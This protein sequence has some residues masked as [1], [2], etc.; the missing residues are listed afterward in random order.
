LLR[1]ARA[2]VVIS[3][4]ERA[5]L[6]AAGLPAEKLRVIRPGV[7]VPESTLDA[8]AFRAE[9]EIPPEAPLL[10]AVGHL[11]GHG[12]AHDA[13]WAFEMMQYILPNLQ[14]ALIGDGRNRVRLGGYFRS[15]RQ[16]GFGLR[17]IGS[18]ADAA[19]L[20]QHADVALISHRRLG[21]T[22]STLEAMAAGRPVVATRLPHLAEIIRDGE[23]GILVPP[24]DQSA[25]ARSV[26][27]LLDNKEMADGIGLAAREQVQKELRVE[28]MAAGFSDLYQELMATD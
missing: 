2:I 11:E 1:Q 15:A 8:L 7:P 27:R 23:T 5:A 25:L 18:R 13:I 10:M 16:N 26:L 20:I 6:T 21:G 19:A 12:R 17:F 3:D 9:Y 24:A 22:F 28:T 14:L 4:A